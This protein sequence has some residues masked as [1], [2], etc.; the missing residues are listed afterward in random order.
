MINADR[1]SGILMHISSLPGPFGV[2]VLGKEA[3]DFIDLI[4]NMGFKIWQVLPLNP[5]DEVHS[6][7]KST[8]AFA[9]DYIYIDP[10]SLKS[11][12]LVS[13]S[14]IE[15]CY[16]NCDNTEA[17]YNFAA[18]K[19]LALLKIAFSRLTDTM[20]A[21]IDEF[22]SANKWVEPYALYCAI[23]D[24][25]NGSP[26]WDWSLGMDDYEYCKNQHNKF[27]HSINFYKF[28]QYIFYLQWSV[29]KNY[30]NSKGIK[31]MGDMPFYLSMDSADVWSN[32][33]YF[34]LN[35]DTLKPLG[36]AGVPPDYYSPDGQLWGNPLYDWEVLEDEGYS[37]WISR[38]THLTQNFDIVRMDHF[39]AFASYWA[40]DPEAQTA[41]YGMWVEGPGRKLFNIIKN[42][43]PDANLIAEDLGCIGDDVT[44]LL[45][46]CKYPGMRVFQ[47]GLNDMGNSIHL[48]HNFSTNC[49]AYIG[50]HD[51]DTLVGFLKSMP[52]IKRKKAFDYISFREND[53]SQKDYCDLA[54][55]Y[56]IET[57][58]RSNASLVMASI[59]DICGLDSDSRMNTPGTTNK[60]W[61][62]RATQEQLNSID[63]DYFTNINNL[64]GRN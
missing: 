59:Q 13:D 64:Y 37:W 23:K 1:G 8:S 2:G 4:S 3:L 14:E 10:R 54:C 5:V 24:Y 41:K 50:T 21:S 19:R 11:I 51:S 35:Q 57:L 17:Q 61:T 46:F 9:G 31:I 32:P 30:A 38:L 18:T 47:F 63:R 56:T 34:Q 55:Q 16:C 42:S 52:D 15:A 53:L 22:V 58:W 33:Y 62:F 6:P 60:N 44:D 36:V 26:W 25:N 43:L 48:P 20:K 45:D 12:G 28:I 49:I 39:R 29:V 27:S 40:V 7:Y